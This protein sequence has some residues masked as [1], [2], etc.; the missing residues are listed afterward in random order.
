[1]PSIFSHP[2]VP[3]AIGYGLGK[4]PIPLAVVV[5]G[6]VLSIVPDLDS[7]SFILGIPYASDYGHRGF[8]HS[9]VFAAALAGVCAFSVFREIRLRSFWFLF[10][11]AASHGLL[12]AFTNGGHGIALLWPFTSERFF[13]PFQVIEV[14]PIGKRFFSERGIA[15]ILSELTWVWLPSVVLGLALKFALRRP[16]PPADHPPEPDRGAG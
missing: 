12:D 3:L 11:S 6:I 2:A 5:T 4:S 16:S 1:M 13:A 8:T 15:V 10:I 7:I 9:L 14:S